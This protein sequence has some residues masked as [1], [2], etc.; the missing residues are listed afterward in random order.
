MRQS[1][2][3]AAYAASVLFLFSLGSAAVSDDDPAVRFNG[4]TAPLLGKAWTAHV[5][6]KG[7]DG[8]V[9]FDGH[10]VRK[11]R[12][13]IGGRFLIEEAYR[14]EA[15][16]SLTHIGLMASGLDGK[17]GTVH[18]ASFWPWQATALPSAS[19]R[20]M[21]GTEGQAKLVLSSTLEPADAPAQH[22]E[23]SCGF[24]NTDVFVC[25]T[26]SRAGDGDA[27]ESMRATY[28]PRR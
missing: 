25:V 3:F 23:T 26:M 15:D 11:F 18:V 19:G 9:G 1:S 7:P 21:T 20:L 5:V 14:E 16:G 17:T 8:T 10:D 22:H 13:G 6:M 4:F 24:E 12:R 2:L 27:F 28:T